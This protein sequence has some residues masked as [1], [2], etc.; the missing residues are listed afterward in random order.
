[1]SDLSSRSRVIRPSA[2]ACVCLLFLL[3]PLSPGPGKATAEL[4]FCVVKEPTLPFRE[5]VF[6]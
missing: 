6:S 2:L 5:W 1:M 4:S 3:L